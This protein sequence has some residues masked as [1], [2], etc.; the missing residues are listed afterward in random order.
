MVKILK[1][2]EKEIKIYRASV[3]VLKYDIRKDRKC[4]KQYD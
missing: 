1:D 2:I 4:L 3:E